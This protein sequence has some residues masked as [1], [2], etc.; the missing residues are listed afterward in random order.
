MNAARRCTILKDAKTLE[1]GSNVCAHVLI[2]PQASLVEL[3]DE[4]VLDAVAVEVSH[5]RS[6]VPQMFNVQNVG[7]HEHGSWRQ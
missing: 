2:Y 6:G 3:A 5:K 1:P 7:A 4:Q